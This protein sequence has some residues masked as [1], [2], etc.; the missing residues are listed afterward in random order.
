M[1][2][3]EIMAAMKG[4]NNKIILCGVSDGDGETIIITASILHTIST[5]SPCICFH[6]KKL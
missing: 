1:I 3:I 4:W 2:V 5:V 6:T